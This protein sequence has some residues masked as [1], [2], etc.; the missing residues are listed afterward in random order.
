MGITV[1]LRPSYIYGWVDAF[2]LI[3]HAKEMYPEIDSLIISPTQEEI[4]LADAEPQTN[5]LKMEMAIR[6]GVPV[7]KINYRIGILEGYK[8]VVE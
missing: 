3:E 1:D 5:I 6:D 8:V 4:L 7:G 2:N